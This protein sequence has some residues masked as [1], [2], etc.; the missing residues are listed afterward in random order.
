MPDGAND[1]YQKIG[2]KS[3]CEWKPKS[4]ERPCENKCFL[5]AEFLNHATIDYSRLIKYCEKFTAETPCTDDTFA[6]GYRL[7]EDFDI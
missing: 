4:A 3:Y 6:D 7:I 5:K 1:Y 2:S